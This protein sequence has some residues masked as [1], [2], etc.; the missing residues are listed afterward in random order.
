M[1]I[2]GGEGGGDGGD[3]KEPEERGGGR[4]RSHLF[5]WT[6]PTVPQSWVVM[7]A[8]VTT[9]RTSFVVSY[10]LEFPLIYIVTVP[11]PLVWVAALALSCT[12]LGEVVLSKLS[13]IYNKKSVA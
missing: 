3:E 5:G 1:A 9:P 12:Y 11:Q 13:F 7:Y 10:S 6:P 2:T 8:P 4:A